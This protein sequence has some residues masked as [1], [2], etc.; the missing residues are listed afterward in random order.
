MVEDVYSGTYALAPDGNITFT[1]NRTVFKFAKVEA[2][3]PS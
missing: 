2:L 1:A 3:T